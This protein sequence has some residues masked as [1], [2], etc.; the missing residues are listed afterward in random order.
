MFD[1]NPRARQIALQ[2]SNLSPNRVTVLG[3]CHR[4]ADSAHP[5]LLCIRTTTGGLGEGVAPRQSPSTLQ[6]AP[7]AHPH[8][9]DVLI[10]SFNI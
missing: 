7:T 10:I 1:S 5:W 9:R 6:Q 8:S 3:R 2:P 4:D